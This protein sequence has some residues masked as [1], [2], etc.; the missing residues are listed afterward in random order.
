MASTL[1]EKVCV[2]IGKIYIEKSL[3]H[4]LYCFLSVLLLFIYIVLAFFWNTSCYPATR[5]SSVG[6][7]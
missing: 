7:P 2:D 5:P 3:K 1:E 4:P 6:D